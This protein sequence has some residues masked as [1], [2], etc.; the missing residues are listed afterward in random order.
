[1]KKNKK[2]NHSFNECIHKNNSNI[3]HYKKD[4][5]TV[6]KL[7]FA[8]YN[9]NLSNFNALK[10]NKTI[11]QNDYNDNQKINFNF[12]DNSNTNNTIGNKYEKDINKFTNSLKQLKTYFPHNLEIIELEKNSGLKAPTRVENIKN[13]KRLKEEISICSKEENEIRQKKEKFEKELEDIENKIIDL[14]MNID[15]AKGFEKENNNKNIRDKLI[16]KFEE[17]FLEK[18]NNNTIK[19]RKSVYMKEL[20]EELNLFLQREEYN[21]QQKTK[22]IENDIIKNKILKKEINEKL[23][24]I[25]ENLRNI[26]RKKNEIINKLY[27]HY[28]SILRDGKDTRNEGL[29]WVIK[30]IFSLDKKVMLSFMPTF[31][32]KLCVKYLFNMTYLNIEIANVEKEIKN[33]KHEFK[34]V[35]VF[36][37]GNDFLIMG[38]IINKSN[39]TNKYLNER[40]E[41]MMEYLDKI[42]QTFCINP[43]KNKIKNS[44]SYCIKN[45]KNNNINKNSPL[46]N[47]ILLSLPYINGDP[48]SITKSNKE[49]DYSNKLLKENL[50]Q[51]IPNKLK[52]KDLEKMT[53]KTGYFVNNEEVKKVQN[54]LN[55]NKKLNNLRKKKEIMKTNEMSRIFKEFQR[56]DYAKRFNIDKIKVI[57]ALIGEDNINSELVKQSK[58]EKKYMEEIMKG[59]MHKRMKVNRQSFSVK[60]FYTITQFNSLNKIQKDSSEFDHYRNNEDIGKR[61]NSFENTKN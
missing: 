11:D 48:N 56:N 6:L 22:N 42:R 7:S 52:L 41:S 37:D 46:K 38:S 3:F 21:N 17:D 47:K 61:F 13:E 14:Q 20:Q 50:I 25:L 18:E 27:L 35:G 60:N 36:S 5:E 15:V 55:L 40:N 39:I 33:C 49:I 30:E 53:K 54:Y 32:D 19:R 57:S 23:I 45:I 43:K 4:V 28:L 29:C 16:S 58:R 24:F 12:F 10:E 34:K 44:K 26:H 51:Q 9:G 2:K 1:M 8:P 31:L 59:R